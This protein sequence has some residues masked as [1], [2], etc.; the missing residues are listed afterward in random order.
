MLRKAYA[1]ILRFFEKY[2]RIF[3]AAACL[4]LAF[5]CFRCL[6]V[7]Y[8][9]SWDEAR[10]GVNAY[11]MIQNG[12]YIRHTYN[13]QVDDWNLKPSVSYW[14]IALAFRIFGYSVFS[15]RFF[16]ALSYLAAGIACGLFARRYSKEASIFVLGFFCAN[17]RPLSAHLARSGDADALFFLFFTLA[18]LA[19]LR[20]RKKRSLLYFCGL[21][22]SLAFL[23][24]S[25]H[26]GMIG[27]CVGLYLLFTGELFR[28]K[29]KEW[30]FFLL[31]VFAPLLFW[32][33]WRFTRDG[34]AFP[35]Q[36]LE[37]DLLARTGSSNFEGH[38]YPFSFYYDT[39]FGDRAFI[40]PWLIGI[41][42][43]GA[44]A[45]LV[46]IVWKKAWK[47]EIF[48]DCLGL[49]LWFFV[50][51]LGFS[52]VGTKLIWYCYPC[53]A[54]LFLG[55]AIL[56]GFFLRLP[57]AFGEGEE[58]FA[59]AGEGKV[60]WKQEAFTG[61]TG[62]FA[63]ALIFMTVYYMRDTYFTVIRGA[64]GDG[65][66]LFVEES[67]D[68]DDAYAGRKAYIMAPTEK[69]ENLGSWDQN[70]LF[71]AEISGDFHCA[72]GGVEGFLKESAPAVL[73]IDR[74]RYGQY[75]ESLQGMEILHEREDYLLLGN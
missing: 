40:Y 30:G 3:F 4:T 21:L 35:R 42:L 59:H 75:E 23:T 1:G 9:D 46:W 49:C 55:A 2:D 24:K 60:G 6:D 5:Y 56:I 39:V 67:V 18:M 44:L 41:C 13:Y 7:Q 36:M 15:L 48:L 31:S 32:F 27:A 73:Y 53:T 16:S 17:T 54:P 38:E 19:M 74:G 10:H 66:Q 69:P 65:L 12:D 62:L 57:L 70:V 47:K 28:L 61:I 72:T 14:A 43:L 37:V 51:F 52:L 26:A 50:P 29:L 22:F 71:M 8:V 20:I 68:R 45:G 64:H 11:E 58:A 25:W 34:L 63:A 33:G